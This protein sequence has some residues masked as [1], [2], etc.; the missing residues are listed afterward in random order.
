MSIKLEVK[1]YC[2]D[3]CDFEADVV[4][5][6]KEVRY[7]WDPVNLEQQ[8][9]VHRTDTT[10]KCKYARRCEGMMRHLSEIKASEKYEQLQIGD[11]T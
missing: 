10:V 6:E 7:Y 2:A 9:K 8:T 4:K 11:V 3:C 5:G 1:P